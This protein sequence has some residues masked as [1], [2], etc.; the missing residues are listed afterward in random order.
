MAIKDW[1]CAERPREKL[2]QNGAACLSD[3][4]LLAIFIRDGTQNQTAVDIARDM[5][6]K[7]DD[8]RNLLNLDIKE[9]C[10]FVGIG[11]VK[12]AYL[13][14]ALEIGR[15][16]LKQKLVKGSV[17]DSP[18]TSREYLQMRLRDK[19][20]EVFYAMF[21]D[22][23]NRIL[24]SKELFRGTIDGANVPIREVVKEALHYNAAAMIVAHNHPSGVAEPSLSD[25]NMTVQLK[26]ALDLV[27]V[28]LL[29]HFV[30]GD[31][32]AS[33]LAE[34]GLC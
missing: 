14:A 10:Q 5:L 21:L 33:S 30:I 24:M 2:L 26:Q 31:G 16:Y 17:I 3:A 19:P 8:L 34:L 22:N 28:K 15:R 7:H 9:F 4:E 12:Y 20:Y 27:G 1:P 6:N 25:K 18:L 11:E 32:E 23:K 29:D 13:Q